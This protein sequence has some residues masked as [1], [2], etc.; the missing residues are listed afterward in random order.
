[1]EMSPLTPLLHSQQ[2]T[3]VTIKQE[4]CAAYVISIIVIIMVIATCMY[5]WRTVPSASP[6]YRLP[7]GA[8]LF[9]LDGVEIQLE[10]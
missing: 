4:E 8:K 6:V 10:P 3:S 7:R 2:Q 9:T 5:K 1:M